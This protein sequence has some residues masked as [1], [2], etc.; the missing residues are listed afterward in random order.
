MIIVMV[1][2]AMM[3][4]GTEHMYT[5]NIFMILADEDKFTGFTC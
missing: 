2:A 5:K 4:K 3:K 1:A